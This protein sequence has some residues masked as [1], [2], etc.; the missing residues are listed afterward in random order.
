MEFVIAKNVVI[1]QVAIN[2]VQL[3]PALRFPS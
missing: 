2:Q 1:N 3:T